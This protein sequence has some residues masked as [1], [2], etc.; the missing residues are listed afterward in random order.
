MATNTSAVLS[1][2]SYKTSSPSNPTPS[3]RNIN[4][5]A[6]TGLP[7]PTYD[8]AN[9]S[10]IFMPTAYG[11]GASTGLIHPTYGVANLSGTW[12][13]TAY[14]TGTIG[15]MAPSTGAF[16]RSPT[17]VPFYSGAIKNSFYSLYLLILLCTIPF[18]LVARL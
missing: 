12:M 10:G 9:V 18:L 11:T 2:S 6:S 13:P 17:I 15:I 8:M 16:P 1:K 4:D 14:G 7:H 3:T 5:T